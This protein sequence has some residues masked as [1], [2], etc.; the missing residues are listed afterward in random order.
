MY[1]VDGMQKTRV[2]TRHTRTPSRN[3]VIQ[4]TKPTAENPAPVAWS[5]DMFPNRGMPSETGRAMWM[6]ISMTSFGCI[7]GSAYHFGMG[8]KKCLK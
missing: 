4:P 2:C 6:I 3:G 5:P 8:P 1:T 7:R